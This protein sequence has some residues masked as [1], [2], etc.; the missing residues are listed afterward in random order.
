MGSKTA[1]SSEIVNAFR[2]PIC[3]EKLTQSDG[4]YECLADSCGMKYPVVDGIPV[5]INESNSLFD[6]S[7]FTEKRYTFALESRRPKIIVKLLRLLPNISINIKGRKNYRLLTQKLL[8]KSDHPKVLVLGGGIIGQG[9]EELAENPRIELVETDVTIAERTQIIV[10]A[11]DIPFADETFDCVIAQAVLEHVINPQ[12]CV[13]EFHRVLKQNGYIYVETP[14]MQQV[15]GRPY[16][17][18]RFTEM[19]HRSLLRDF[20]EVSSGAVTGPGMALAWSIRHF[21]LS[22]GFK[23]ASRALVDLFVRLTAWHWK[24]FDYLI[25][26]TD[27]ARDAASGYYFLGQKTGKSLTDRDIIR[28][29]S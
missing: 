27:N 8:E 1:L 21:L 9:M 22:F 20:E 25:I 26:G 11:H 14:F 7:D 12:R 15:H 18:T 16:D 19:G 28:R 6:I 23:G 24:Y 3:R 29:Y 2:C 17:F 13:S 10:D 5:L 4:C